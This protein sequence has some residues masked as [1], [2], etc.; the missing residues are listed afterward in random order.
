MAYI[1]VECPNCGSID[2]QKNGK[3]EKRE[4]RYLCKNPNCSKKTFLGKYTYKG[5]LPETKTKILK[6]TFNG[7]GIRDTARVLEISPNTVLSE[8]K[9]RTSNTKS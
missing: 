6:M 7:S 1:Q 5:C 9:K 8:L 2:I 4:Q 3:D